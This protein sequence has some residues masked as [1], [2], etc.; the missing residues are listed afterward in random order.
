MF[1]VLLKMLSFFAV[2]IDSQIC[3]TEAIVNYCFKLGINI[4]KNRK[5]V[6]KQASY[7]AG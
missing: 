7:M 3:E 2:H 6:F 4:L 5:M 1:K